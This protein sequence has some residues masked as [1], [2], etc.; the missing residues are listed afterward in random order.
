MAKTSGKKYTTEVPNMAKLYSVTINSG[1]ASSGTIRERR[2]E[3]QKH[4]S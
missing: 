1:T 3:D 2:Q 4:T